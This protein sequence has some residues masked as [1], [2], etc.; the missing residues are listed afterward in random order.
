VNTPAT[1]VQHEWRIYFRPDST[2]LSTAATE[3]LAEIAATLNAAVVETLS[4]TG[5]C[6]LAGSEAGRVSI[7]IGRAQVVADF[8]RGKGVVFP[9]SA[10]VKGVGATDPATTDLDR[11]QLNRRTVIAATY[12]NR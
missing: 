5:H 12:P 9:A 6:A 8:L 1:P 10:V 2:E 4:I 11:Q 7:S 3:S